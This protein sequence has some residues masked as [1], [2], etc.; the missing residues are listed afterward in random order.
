MSLSNASIPIGAS[1]SPTGGSAT[2]LVSLGS[3]E[4]RNKLYIND[5]SDLILRKTCLATSKA[6]APNAGSPNGYTQ[7][8]ST[9]VFHVPMLLANGE[10]TTNTVK[11]EISFDPE[12]DASE[13]AYLRELVA[14][15][16]VDADFDGLLDDG[17]VA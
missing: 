6:P 16:G 13:R 3:S 1:Y 8:R 15:V 5:G 4:G 7:Q 9:I 12:A 11:V 2:T 14:H 17:S 10:Y